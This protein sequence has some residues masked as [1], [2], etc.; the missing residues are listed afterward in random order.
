MSPSCRN[1]GRAMGA[2]W[3]KRDKVCWDSVLSKKFTAGNQSKALGPWGKWKSAGL[4]RVGP[5]LPLTLHPL[6]SH[7]GQASLYSVSILLPCTLQR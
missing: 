7:M 2:T 6:P 5:A 3:E 1:I 4:Q